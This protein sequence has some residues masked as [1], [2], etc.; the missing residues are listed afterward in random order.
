[1][2]GPAPLLKVIVPSLCVKVPELSKFPA[3]VVVP[4]VASYVPPEFIV[5]EPKD[6]EPDWDA[7]RVP[8]ITTSD[9][10][11]KLN[12]TPAVCK[13]SYIYPDIVEHSMNNEINTN[14]PEKY[15]ISFIKKR[16]D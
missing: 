2:S 15:L 8:L 4:L 7:F 9:V 16:C 6:S 5:S 1:M 14:N 10:A 13:K 12:H 11:V 3:I